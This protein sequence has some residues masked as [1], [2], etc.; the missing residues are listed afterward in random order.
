VEIK[1]K[2][3]FVYTT[4]Y[5][6]GIANFLLLFGRE[7]G[8]KPSPCCRHCVMHNGE[9]WTMQL[10]GENYAC[11]DYIDREIIRHAQNDHSDDRLLATFHSA[12]GKKLSRG[13][14]WSVR[15]KTV[16]QN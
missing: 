4:F 3:T 10:H 1:K 5:F 13:N 15:K 14:L 6:A 8:I 11:Q 12:R 2:T 7:Q 16:L 9:Y